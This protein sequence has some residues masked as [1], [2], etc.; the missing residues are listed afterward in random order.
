MKELFELNNSYDDL[1]SRLTELQGCLDVSE[2]KDTASSLYKETEDPA[3]WKNPSKAKDINRKLADCNHKI[4]KLDSFEKKLSTIQESLEFLKIEND[5]DI[6][7]DADDSLVALTKEF[8]EFEKELFYSG[9]YDHLNAILEFH[10]GAGGTEAHDWAGMLLRMYERYC[11]LAGFTF[12]VLDLI[13]GEEAGISSCTLLVQGK[14]A[15]GNLRSE[16]GVHRLVR[17]SPFDADGA[18]HTSFASVSVIPEIDDSIEVVINPSDLRIDTYHSSGAGGQ[19]VN[20]TESAVRITHIPTGIVVSC[21]IERDQLAN[22]ETCMAEL[23]SKL[24]QLELKKREEELAKV[25]GVKKDISFSSQIRSYV[26]SPYQL[27]KDHRSEYSENTITPVMDG[28]IQSFIDAYLRWDF[29][30]TH[31]VHK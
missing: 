16:N 18:R 12:K 28:H 17:N 21:Q 15:F 14:M 20:K 25:S 24:F 4:E 2:L 13:P 8:D 9:D 6:F 3:F 30:R 19:N 29:K 27:V 23:K 7:H 5:A 31:E 1:N 22:K 10:P 11:D 26:F